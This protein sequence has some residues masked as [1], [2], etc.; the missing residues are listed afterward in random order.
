M[1][2][3]LTLLVLCGLLPAAPSWAEDAA[4]FP[5]KS[6]RVVIPFPPGGAADTFGR[7]IGAKLGEAWSQ[8]V[9]ADNKPGA[10]GQVAT[11]IVAG[12]PGDG[13]TMLIVTVGHA[14]NPSLYP[15]LPYNTEKDLKPVAMIA[16]APSVLVVNPA[17]KA[18]SVAELLALAKA[19]P[20]ELNYASSGNA[21]TSHI[22]G[23]L[24]T[25]L[26]KVDMTHVPYRGSAP[27]VTDLIGGQVQLMIDPIV[28]SAQ[29]VKSGKLRALAISSAQRS[30]LAP[31]L[32]PIAETVTGYDFSA[33]FVLLVPA[34]TPDAI[35]A[36]LNAQVAKALDAA[37]VKERY[38]TLG[39]EPGSGSPAEV[40]RFLS[41]E[42]KR[43]AAV[44]KESGMK[45]D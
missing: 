11:Q 37:D 43:Y 7:L 10:G 24:L 40:A 2:R 38:V 18:N 29:H 25:T 34:S 22:A 20:K 21:S 6:M 23:V 26:G 16:R 14:V 31:D 1:R 42:I 39:A 36:K 12:A 17:V 33:W 19:K 28:S 9:V 41:D 5:S 8:P 35:V 15:N 27:A 45:A 32:P 4:A 44:V 13:Y 3:M 30:P